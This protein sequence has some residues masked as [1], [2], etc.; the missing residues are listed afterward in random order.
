[1]RTAYKKRNAYRQICHAL[2][3]LESDSN[4]SPRVILLLRSAKEYEEQGQRTRGIYRVLNKLYEVFNA[5]SSN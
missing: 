3:I 4:S 5:R 2:E 1:M